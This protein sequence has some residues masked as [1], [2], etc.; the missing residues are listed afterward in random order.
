[1]DA[2]RVEVV[3]ELLA[4][5]EWP[6]LTRSFAGSLRG[7]VRRGPAGGL[8][9]V[10]SGEYEPW[11]MAAHLDDEAA[12]S[13]LPELSPTLVRHRV[14][15][16]APAHLAVG[17]ARLEAARRGETVLVVTPSGPRPGCWSGWRTRGAP[18]RR[19]WRWTRATRSCAGWRT[20]R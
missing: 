10:G 5:S 8:L 17:T 3:R 16:G 6:E 1:M 9:L 19:C 13:G 20:R 12:W 14:P 18:A 4:G 11:H 15:P 7:S 2:V